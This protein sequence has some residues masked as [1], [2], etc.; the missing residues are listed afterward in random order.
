MSRAYVLSGQAGSDE[1]ERQYA[2]YYAAIAQQCERRIAPNVTTYAL[3]PEVGR[4]SI[5]VTRLQGGMRVV[6]YNV[7]FATE[8]RVGYRFSAERF[9][10][11]ACLDGRLRIVEEAAGQ[12][13]LGQ[14]S[15]SL[16]PP[17][18]TAGT[19]I[20]PAGQHYRGVSLTGRR[21]GL[22]PYLGN[23]DV[24]AFASSLERLGSSRGDE[25]YL[26]QGKKLHGVPN[27]L[28]ELY[29]LRAETAGKTLLME[30]RVMA[31]LALL[32]DASSGEQDH[33]IRLGLADHEVDALRRVPL[34]LWRERHDLPP[35]ADVARLLSMSSK[36]LAHGFKALFG[37]PPLEYHRRQCIERAAD[38]LVDTDWTVERIG[39]EVGYA[40]ASNFVYAF[41]RRLG[42]TPAE[43]RRTHL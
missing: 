22:S 3:L 35:L 1:L 36:R 27:L 39:S 32:L 25:L 18:P 5:E 23:V 7:V 34:I 28:A 15:S 24:E 33:E 10:L 14:F 31:V 21:D 6:R 42:C 43:Y 19:L 41:R 8:H 16:T 30:S 17:R 37:V 20:H 12:S 38:L 29:G 4:G 13:E 11:E 26:G 40:A 2:S 9:E